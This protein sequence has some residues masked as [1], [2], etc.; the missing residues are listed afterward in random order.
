MSPSMTAYG[1]L[2][3]HGDCKYQNVVAIH[4]IANITAITRIGR[5][6][7]NSQALDLWFILLFV[8]ITPF[9]TF[10]NFPHNFLEQGVILLHD[11]G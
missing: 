4:I 10:S 1:Y 5:S 8:R 11:R 2:G 7:N 6:M 3:R 9:S